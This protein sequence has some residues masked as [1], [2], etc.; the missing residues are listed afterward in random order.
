MKTFK[1]NST[2]LMENKKWTPSG[3]LFEVIDYGKQ[4]ITEADGFSVQFDTKEEAD[5]Y[6]ENYYINK[7]YKPSKIN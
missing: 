5:N 6:F 1:S 7:G 3:T 4:I 2:R